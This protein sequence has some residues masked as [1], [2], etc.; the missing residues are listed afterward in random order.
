MQHRDINEYVQEKIKRLNLE[1]DMAKNPGH[2]TPAI[3]DVAASTA[4]RSD[5]SLI[6]IVKPLAANEF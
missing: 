4:G 6:D 1:S 3:S 5:I 2:Y